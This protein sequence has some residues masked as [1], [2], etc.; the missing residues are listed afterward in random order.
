MFVKVKITKETDN[1]SLKFGKRLE[2]GIK[3]LLELVLKELL[4]PGN[5]LQQVAA[6]RAPV[7]D[8]PNT[9]I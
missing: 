2:S 1:K 7:E 8:I 3:H 5:L 9:A 6:I 4:Q